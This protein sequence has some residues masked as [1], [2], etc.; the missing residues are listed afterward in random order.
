MTDS[1]RQIDI[2]LVEDSPTDIM[3]TRRALKRAKLDNRMFVATTGD[4]ALR[5]LRREPP[6]TDAPRPDLILLDL[7]LPVLP[8]REVL[9][10]I[11]GDP[12][13]RTIP[14][15]VLTTSKDDRVIADVYNLHANCYI[16]KPLDFDSLVEIVHSINRFWFTIVTLPQPTP[17][18]HG[19]EA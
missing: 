7:N 1:S 3:L 18:N 10:V 5:Y 6:H 17:A 11:K 8:G 15:I 2:L 9:K 4:E 19:E 12:E 16:A 13:L 14:V